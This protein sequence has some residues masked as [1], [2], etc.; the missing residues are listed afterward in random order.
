[1]SSK[2]PKR[3]GF[4]LTSEDAPETTNMHLNGGTE[5]ELREERIR[6]SVKGAL[7][8]SGGHSQFEVRV[9][10]NST[11]AEVEKE[12]MLLEHRESVDFF[13]EQGFLDV[14]FNALERL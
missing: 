8:E 4:E 7:R 1:M 6:L 11:T 2:Q 14:A 3:N 5:T 9:D 13:I 10:A 12:K